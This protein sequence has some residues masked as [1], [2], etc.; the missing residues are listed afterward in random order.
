MPTW[1]PRGE[2]VF[3]AS[4]RGIALS[5]AQGQPPV[6]VFANGQ[7]GRFRVA[8]RT[9]A[10][11]W[12]IQ[13]PDVGTSILNGEP[14]IGAEGMLC[15]VMQQRTTSVS[16]HF[17]HAI[18]GSTSASVRLKTL[19]LPSWSAMVWGPGSLPRPSSTRRWG[20]CM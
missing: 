18:Q 11:A 19:N 8:A 15:V 10:N 7:T 17:L 20:Y 16:T 1:W 12:S 3:D 2:L 9:A 13:Q 4:G 6:V 14:V 5:P